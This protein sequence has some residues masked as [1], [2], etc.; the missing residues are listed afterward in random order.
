MSKYT[1]D[2]TVY[3]SSDNKPISAVLE[4]ELSRRGVLKRGGALAAFT[5]L[6]SLGLTG[7]NDDNSDD[8]ITPPPSGLS[9][10]F[11]SIAGSKT[12]A[13]SVPAGYTAQVLAP[14]G[15]PL[16]DQAAEWKED[17]TNTSEDQLN[18]T[19]MMHD[20]MHFFPLDGSS[21]EGLL[22]MNHEFIDQNR[23][24]PAGATVDI[25]PALKDGDSYS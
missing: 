2:P 22:C 10:G 7:C 1:F 14:W 20:G 5:A 11:E 6:A 9:L 12:D 24:H 25:L 19:G 21:T 15:T 17:G 16:N 13:V 4:K 8:V 18:A 3:N 23:L